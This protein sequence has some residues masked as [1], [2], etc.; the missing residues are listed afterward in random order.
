[1]LACGIG[2]LVDGW[3]LR[4]RGVST[5]AVVESVSVFPRRSAMKVRFTTPEGRAVRGSTSAIPEPRPAPGD[6]VTVVYDP[7]EPEDVSLPLGGPSPVADAGLVAFGLVPGALYGWYLRRTWSHWRGQAEDW[8]QHR[9][10]PPLGERQ[11]PW[12]GR[13][14]AETGPARTARRRA[15]PGRP[16]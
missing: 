6:V 9:P 15:G 3:Q 16:I 8:R 1:M 5:P 7:A 4:E 11:Y 14:R 13:A 2:A 10:V 12:P